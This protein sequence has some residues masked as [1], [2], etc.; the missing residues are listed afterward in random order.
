M[1]TA[2]ASTKYSWP[3][4]VIYDQN[5]RQEAA[6]NSLKDWA[7]VD[8]SIYTQ[9]FTNAAV[10]DEKWCKNRQS[11]NHGSS[12]CP[13]QM[14]MYQSGTSGG[15]GSS[16][17]RNRQNSDQTYQKRLPPH[18]LPQTCRLYNHF[19]GDCKFGNLR[20]YQHKCEICGKYGHPRNQCTN[21]LKAKGS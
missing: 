6:D 16:S 19:N 11:I 1:T 4:W 17:S 12:T 14:Y 3:S 8:P 21:Q 7:K 9:R 13:L 2:K 10:N 18:S 5:F 15:N 20:T